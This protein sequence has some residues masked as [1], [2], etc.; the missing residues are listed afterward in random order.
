MQSGV[1]APNGPKTAPFDRWFRYP[2]GFN[3]GTLQQCFALLGDTSGGLVVDPFAGVCTTGIQARSLGFEFLGLE[4]HPFI[5]ELAALKFTHPADPS[6][7]IAL[8][9]GITQRLEINEAYDELSLVERSFSPETL[10]WLASLRD[11]IKAL[12][13]NPWMLYL[14]WC[15]LGALRECA[16]VKV[17]WPYQRPAVSRTPRIIDPQR[18]FMRRVQ[19]MAEDLATTPTSPVASVH[20]SDARLPEDWT[21]TIAQRKAAAII[22][23]PPYLNNFDYADATRLE[24]YFWGTVRSWLQMTSQIRSGMIIAS[25]Q[26]S[27][28]AL[29]E[30]SAEILATLCPRSAAIIE[31]LTRE[32]RQERLLRRN[33]KQ[34]DQVLPSYFADL[35]H[36]LINIREHGLPRAP[37][38]L[39]VGDSAP[40]G[41]YIDT[42][43][44][45]GGISEELGFTHASV[46]PIRH[47]GHRWRTNGIRHSVDLT[48]KVILL[49]AP[50]PH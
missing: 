25:T 49:Q 2:A 16:S 15:L 14:K 31:R 44:L 24:L 41:V 42:P 3:S 9:R 33:G 11:R 12:R 19:W 43:A 18:A 22:T 8:A 39:V 13:D 26:Q 34:Y 37:V 17:G 50:G 45:L 6:E 21:R 32:V 5:A 46:L 30:E 36:V 27:R 4:A 29:A 1:G 7:L 23:S 47:R 10:V 40:Y 20:I 48:E 28:K 38:I 35:T